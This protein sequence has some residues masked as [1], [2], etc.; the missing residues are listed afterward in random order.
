MD[1]YND[2]WYA[3]ALDLAEKVELEESKPRTA[4]RRTRSNPPYKSILEYHKRII[5]NSFS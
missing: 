4:G 2:G 5:N 1:S 3:V